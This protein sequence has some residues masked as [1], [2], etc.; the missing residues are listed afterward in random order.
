MRLCLRLFVINL[1]NSMKS[2]AK[3][4]PCDSNAFSLILIIE[5]Y[6]FCRVVV[7]QCKIWDW[8]LF[9][10]HTYSHNM[11]L[12]F[13]WLALISSLHTCPQTSTYFLENILD[14]S[15]SLRHLLESNHK[16]ISYLWKECN[17]FAVVDTAFIPLMPLKACRLPAAAC[18]SCVEFVKVL[19]IAPG[20]SQTAFLSN[21]ASRSHA[22]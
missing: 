20:E 11:F 13:Q 12:F 18:Q 7:I 6:T 21:S 22:T 10:T 3:K 15:G 9:S 4:C 14:F 17:L 8:T 1:I 5:R 16:K 2:T 19:Y